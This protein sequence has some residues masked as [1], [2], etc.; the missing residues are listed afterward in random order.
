MTFLYFLIVST[1]ILGSLVVLC[2]LLLALSATRVQRRRF[3]VL[4]KLD[5]K[6]LHFAIGAF[7]F[8]ILSTVSYIGKDIVTTQLSVEV[9]RGPNGQYVLKPTS[10]AF[11]RELN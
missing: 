9:S 8:L 6:K 10:I 2:T 7:V 4:T 11:Q 3:P 5:G 1:Y